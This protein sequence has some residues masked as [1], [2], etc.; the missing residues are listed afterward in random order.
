MPEPRPRR[1]GGRRPATRRRSSS[2]P[3]QRGRSGRPCWSWSAPPPRRTASARS[4]S[5]SCCTCGTAATPGRATCCSS[6]TA[7]WPATRTWTRPT[8]S[9]AR[10]ASWSST[11]PTAGRGSACCWPAR[12]SA[13]AGDR[14]APAVGARRPARRG[15]ARRGGRLRPGP[16]AVADAALAADPAR[17]GRSCADGITVRTF[18]TGQDEDEWTRAEQPGL[19]PPS[20]AGRMDPRR[21][22]TCASGSPG[23][24]RTGSSWPSGTAGWSAFTGPR[25][26]ARTATR[27]TAIMPTRP[28]ARSTW[29]ASTRRARHRPRP[30]ADPGRPALPALPRPVPGHAVRRRD[31]HAGDPAV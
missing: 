28:S 25:S 11:R 14:A 9:R 15:P 20:G 3:D 26:T 31:Q 21:T 16:G 6:A 24:T 4:P 12:W 29:S 1:P 27:A 30:R 17:T 2:G 7:S 23:S 22:S 5:T 18:V 13:E 10:A 8:R 19:R